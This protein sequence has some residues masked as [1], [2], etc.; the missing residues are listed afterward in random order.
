MSS[1]LSRVRHWLGDYFH[2][3]RASWA[4]RRFAPSD[5][6]AFC[7]RQPRFAVVFPA[8]NDLPPRWAAGIESLL[9]QYYPHWELLV[10]GDGASH[11][12]D[13]FASRARL[14]GEPRVQ[15]ENCSEPGAVAAF[16]HGIRRVQGDFVILVNGA[17]EFTPDALL[18][19]AVMHQKLPEAVW[20]Y[21][22]EYQQ[23]PD[24]HQT[25]AL[26]RRPAYSPEYLLSAVCVPPVAVFQQDLV[27][28]TVMSDGTAVDGAFYD[29][30]L[31]VSEQVKAD[32][33]VQIPHALYCRQATAHAAAKAQQS[34]AGQGRLAQLRSALRRRKLVAEVDLDGEA[35]SL[36]RLRFQPQSTPQVAVIIPTRDRFEL[37]SRCLYSAMAATAYPNYKFVII[38]N[39]SREP[40]LALLL[41][42]LQRVRPVQVVRYDGPF[43]HSEMHNRLVPTLDAELIVFLNND[44]DGFSR[45]WLEQLVATVQ[46]DPAVAGAGA[47]L[48]YPD[49][50]LQHAGIAIGLT[51][52]AANVSGSCTRNMPDIRART[53]ALQQVTAVTAA[54]MI[55]RKDAFLRVG[56]F[57]ARRYPTSYN[58][59]DL[60]LRLYDAGYRCIY[61]PEVQAT[62]REGETRGRHASP[63]EMTY[64]ERLRHDLSKRPLEDPFWRRE[65]FN[66]LRRQRRDYTRA[67]CVDRKLR[68]L[69]EA[70]AT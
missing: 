3:L 36:C 46:L 51:G 37:L 2:R 33:V 32:Q 19:L 67:A 45:G 14:H 70:A 62:H 44:V 1:G 50:T 48:L 53:R 29:L 54:L 63:Q 56:G 16:N 8:C 47:R 49:G 4:Y 42:D 26:Y 60:W 30:Y 23:G 55:L 17:V 31:R 10:V 21:S 24:S 15:F 5:I 25:G 39:Q 40:E 9:E 27:K 34:T 11:V 59:V 35:D 38:D 61:N 52:S 41:D 13:H 57:D 20:F 28:S 43:N 18:W 68:A 6:V 7:S 69:R 66:S 12:R 22:D 58:D 64:R 65:L